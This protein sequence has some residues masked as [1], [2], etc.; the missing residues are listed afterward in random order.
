[1]L[2]KGAPS[3]VAAPDGRAAVS[4]FVNPVFAT[5]G[6]G[7]VLSGTI[8]GFIAQGA[9]P[10]DA[11]CLGLYVGGLAGQS[12]RDEMGSAGVIAGD[13]L[14]RIPLAMRDL[15]GES[16]PESST[17]VRPDLLQM[18]QSASGQQE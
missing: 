18:L 7:D 6:S 13:F 14:P 1:M 17:A 10:F 3:V 11:V 15:R 8:A 12:L 5:G 2:L 4:P 9:D 16:R